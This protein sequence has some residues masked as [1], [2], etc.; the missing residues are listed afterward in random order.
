MM[1]QTTPVVAPSMYSAAG[2]M[3]A[4][5]PTMSVAQAPAPVTSHVVLPPAGSMVAPAQGQGFFQFCR[6]AQA[7]GPAVAA[8]M[9]VYSQQRVATPMPA[10]LTTMHSMVAAPSMVVAPMA[11]MTQAAP[12]AAAPAVAA[13]A[14]KAKKSKKAAKKGMCC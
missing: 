2:P 9:P 10:P 5:L 11:S 3:T 14:K 4:P 8:S 1:Y 6:P 12:V 7:P 13:V